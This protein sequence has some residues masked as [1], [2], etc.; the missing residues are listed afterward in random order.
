MIKRINLYNFFEKEI[1]SI[2]NTFEEKFKVEGEAF[3][4]DNIDEIVTEMYGDLD[5]L[6]I[7]LESNSWDDI[8]KAALEI[9]LHG[10]TIGRYAR[11][12]KN[13]IKKGG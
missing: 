4:E 8:R 3:T 10:I 2:E 5:K 12:T 6:S 7:L 9:A 13:N 1:T 11:V